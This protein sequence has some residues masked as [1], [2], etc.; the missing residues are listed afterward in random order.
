MRLS[1]ILSAAMLAAAM[2]LS[3]TADTIEATH[4]W[5]RIADINGQLGSVES[6]EFSPDN[7]Y[8]VTGTKYDNTVRVFRTSDGA[9][10]WRTQVPQEIERVAW[11][12]D[13]AF[14]VS[15]S[16][17]FVTRVIDAKTGE[18]V[19]EIMN[20]TGLDSLAASNDGRFMV[21]GQE[22]IAG[23]PLRGPAKVYSTAD[24]SLVRQVDHAETINEIAFLP[25]DSHFFTAGHPWVRMWETE[26]GRL[27]RQFDIV[28][29]GDARQKSN[30]I[31]AGV[32]PD[33]ELL[34]VGATQGYLYIF[35]IETG[36]TLRR[37]NKTGRKI[38]TVSWTP[39]GRFLAAAGH[40]MSVD[41]FSI[42]Y[43][44]DEELE[45]DFIPFAGRV[46]VPAHLEYLSFSSD[47]A[48]MTTAHQDGAVRLYVMMSDDPFITTRRHED[49]KRVQ[50]E[51]AEAATR[52]Q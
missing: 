4:V 10:M 7:E 14:V 6:A 42:E 35:D 40:S 17:D 29:T 20:E 8:I 48:F 39:D 24:W 51:A 46:A 25:D 2:A 22:R 38:E 33:G 23:D 28:D 34:A 47:G 45:D 43:L 13:G 44:R 49:V 19:R 50:R 3:A 31:A 16:E 1:H 27:V 37:F 52:R 9:Q 18:I 26:T 41:F 21:S 12:K 11:T 15:V 32:H 36:E 5:T 30:V